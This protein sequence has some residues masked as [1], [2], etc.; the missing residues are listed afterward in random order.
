[1][2]KSRWYKE[3]DIKKV[4]WNL[5]I[6]FV[7][8]MNAKSFCILINLCILI[9]MIIGNITTLD[10]KP[11]QLGYHNAFNIS[12]KISLQKCHKYVF[13]HTTEYWGHLCLHKISS[14][15]VSNCS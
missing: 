8:M 11:F 7:F 15:V 12:F 1:M 9:V 6:N 14:K 3:C 5:E 4:I 10:E 13:W 2:N